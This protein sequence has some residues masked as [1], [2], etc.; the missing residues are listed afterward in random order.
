MNLQGG[1][2]D[3]SGL[4]G[5]TDI[6]LGYNQLSGPLD[7]LL[8]PNETLGYFWG[9]ESRGGGGGRGVR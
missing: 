8:L 5:V 3:L 9:E 4:S 6:L 2:V 7:P 1:L